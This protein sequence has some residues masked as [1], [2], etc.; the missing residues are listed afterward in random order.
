ML[1]TY[2]D[3]LSNRSKATEAKSSNSWGMGSL[4]VFPPSHEKAC[5]DLL[6]SIRGAQNNM[7]AVNKQN[8]ELGRPELNYGIGVH[9]G[10]VMYGN[11]GP[12]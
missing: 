5:S 4:A 9:V 8:L 6:N 11:I 12:C 10:D 1:N 3:A 7:I 2:F